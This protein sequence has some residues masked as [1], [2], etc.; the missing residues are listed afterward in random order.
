MS[1]Q[2]TI[3]YLI[4]KAETACS[5]ARLALNHGDADGAINRAYYAMFNAARAA[6]LKTGAPVDPSVIRTHSGLIGAFGLYVTRNNPELSAM[7]RILNITQEDRIEADYKVSFFN[8]AD[9]E[10]IVEKAE[11]WVFAI[12]D[13]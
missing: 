13:R 5:T 3:A 12:L 7:G 10:E 8:P 11:N 9:V 2:L 1:S 6:L 4:T